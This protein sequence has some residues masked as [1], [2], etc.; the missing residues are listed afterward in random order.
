MIRTFVMAKKYIV[1]VLG[2]LFAVEA[3]AVSVD[4]LRC[5]NRTNPL[6]IDVAKPRLS[7]VLDSSKQTAYQVVVDGTWDSGK[8]ASDQSVGIEYTG[9]LEAGHALRVEGANLGW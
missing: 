2:V 1:M 8:V 6:G 5:E 7:W 4:R 3:Q 9:S